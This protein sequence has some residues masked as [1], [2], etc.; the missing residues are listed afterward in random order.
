MNVAINFG[1][2]LLCQVFGPPPKSG[3]ATSSLPQHGFARSS[4][5][6]FLGKS[7][8]EDA[9]DS[10]SVKL[11]FGLDKSGLSDDARKAWP[12]D[13]GLVYSVTLSKES[14][15]T[16]ITVRNEGEESFEFQFLLH[17][18]FKIQACRLCRSMRSVANIV[19]GHLQGLRDRPLGHRVHRQGP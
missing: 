14:L 1:S 19:A 7:D 11:D 17:T 2:Q 12:L 8:T 18:Y 13:F 9:L 3:H 15:Q 10:N 5:W 6:E 4:R 16:V